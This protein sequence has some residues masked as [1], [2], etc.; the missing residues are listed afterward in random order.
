MKLDLDEI[1]RLERLYNE[2]GPVDLLKALQELPQTD[3]R[4]V[5]EL[6]DDSGTVQETHHVDDELIAI[7][8]L[9]AMLESPL[10]KEWSIKTSA[11]KKQ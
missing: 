11:G 1:N 8:V 7:M 3:Q 6:I 5:I 2:K 9:A 4:F 10:Q